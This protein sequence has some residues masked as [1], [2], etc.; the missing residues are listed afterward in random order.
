MGKQ[1][2]KTN[3]TKPSLLN[4]HYLV[5]I[6]F[7]GYFGDGKHTYDIVAAATAAENSIQM[8]ITNYHYYR[9]IIETHLFLFI[10]G[11]GWTLTFLFDWKRYRQGRKPCI[12]RNGIRLYC[13]LL[14]LLHSL[15]GRFIYCFIFDND[16]CIERKKSEGKRK[17]FHSELYVDF[18]CAIGEN[19][20][21]KW[22]LKMDVTFMI[23]SG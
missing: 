14:F 7:Y 13:K 21:L 16:L 10:F 15:S 20:I 8:I 12:F 1:T 11:V 19:E 6:R 2:Y 4:G 9:I 17:T 5:V 18:C 23:A 3:K 22:I